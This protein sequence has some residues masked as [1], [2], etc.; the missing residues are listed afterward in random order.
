VRS[1]STSPIMQVKETRVA[2][3]V[4]PFITKVNMSP[5]LSPITKACASPFIMK[6]GVSPIQYIE[7]QTLE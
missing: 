7:R 5:I 4:P 3:G 6:V 2:R 1:C